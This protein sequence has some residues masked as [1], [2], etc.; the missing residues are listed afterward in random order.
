MLGQRQSARIGKQS[1]VLDPERAPN[2][3]FGLG[4]SDLHPIAE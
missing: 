4:N 3:I 1:R 2:D